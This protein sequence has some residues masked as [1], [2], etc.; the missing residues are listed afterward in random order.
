MS[1]NKSELKKKRTHIMINIL[2]NHFELLRTN[3]LK[4]LNLDSK[5]KRILR[6]LY[7]K[8][9]KKIVPV[10]VSNDL[11]VRSITR[12]FD[13]R[14]DT[15]HNNDIANSILTL[16]HKSMPTKKHVSMYIPKRLVLKLDTHKE[17][18]TNQQISDAIIYSYAEHKYVPLYTGLHPNSNMKSVILNV[19]KSV[20][21]EKLMPT[22]AMK[23]LAS[24]IG[25]TKLHNI[26]PIDIHLQTKYGG[27][28][29]D[30]AV[31]IVIEY[32]SV[33]NKAIIRFHDPW[34][35]VESL[36]V[37]HGIYNLIKV[38]AIY[39]RQQFNV[40]IIDRDM[41]L[42]AHVGIQTYSKDKV[43]MCEL[44]TIFWLYTF[45]FSALKLNENTPH[46]VLLGDSI[47]INDVTSATIKGYNPQKIYDEIM[48]FMYKIIS[49]YIGL[50]PHKFYG[51]TMRDIGLYAKYHLIYNNF[52]MLSTDVKNTIKFNQWVVTQQELFKHWKNNTPVD[53]N[54]IQR[55]AAAVQKNSTPISMS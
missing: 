51:F 53:V 52:D 29:A 32:S 16:L 54:R 55:L 21:D 44:F 49:D 33:K 39:I 28:H 27:Q 38:I 19:N 37:K 50:N 4:A 26:T 45:V 42:T 13:Y 25:T 15:H 36:G 12:V 1:D 6:M 23:H 34:G 30:H 22:V 7:F 48:V 8:E 35:S 41:G 47:N 2:R 9:K 11:F 46:Y 17:S 20:N 5:S 10:Y 40:K 43:G 31:A 24:V 18:G 3:Q 14:L